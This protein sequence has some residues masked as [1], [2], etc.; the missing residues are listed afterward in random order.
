MEHS[1]LMSVAGEHGLGHGVRQE[2]HPGDGD[3][4]LVEEN[5][6]GVDRVLA[7]DK[8][9]EIAFQGAGNGA[10]DILLDELVVLGGGEGLGDGAVE[11]VRVRIAER[12]GFQREALERV[13][14]LFRDAA[15]GLGAVELSGRNLLRDRIARQADADLHDLDVQLALGFA[16]GGFQLLARLARIEYLAVADTVRGRFLVV[17]D[18]DVV[19]AD[20]CDGHGE[21]RGAQVDG[22]N[23]FLFHISSICFGR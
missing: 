4:E 1:V 2:V 18:L 3:M 5:V 23:V 13:D 15:V 12:I 10:D 8:D 19:P 11:L 7:A 9:L 16:D 21:F 22:G 6:D 17:D 20:P 14:L